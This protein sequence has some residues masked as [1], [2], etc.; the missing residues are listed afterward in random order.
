MSGVVVGTD[1][2]EGALRA[3]RWAVEEARLRNTRLTVLA[4]V[5]VPV[6]I[7]RASAPF[8]PGAPLIGQ[9]EPADLHAAEAAARAELEQAGGAE[10]VDGEIRVVAG[11]PAEELLKAGEDAELVVVGSR[12]V[13][14][15]S[16]L[17]LG[18]VSSQV[19][20]HATCPVVVIPQKGD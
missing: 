13:G 7:P 6:T 17:L 4:V 2:S 18:S 16:R 10:G 14:G 5:G 3:L 9:P 19:V 20:Q 8:R 15:F 12:G 1:G 11:V